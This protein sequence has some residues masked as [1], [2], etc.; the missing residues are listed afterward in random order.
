[1]TSQVHILC[2]EGPDTGG[3]TGGIATRICD[4]FSAPA[5]RR[6]AAHREFAADLP[7]TVDVPLAGQDSP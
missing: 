1:M 7:Q 3:R 4:L 2:V 6:R 5:G